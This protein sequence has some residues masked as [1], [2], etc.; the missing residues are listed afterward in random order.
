M[1]LAALLLLGPWNEPIDAPPVRTGSLSLK[2]GPADALLRQ[3]KKLRWEERWFEAAG[4][5]RRY[6]AQFPGS[7]REVDARFWLAVTLEQDQRWD[8]ASDAYGDFLA[9]HP[10]QRQL[11][12]EARMNRI[13]CWGV[14]QGQRPG[15][16]EGLLAALRE[17]EPEIRVAAGL[18]LARVMDRRA[19]PA[20]QEGLTLPKQ[21]D[22]ATLALI[23]L[24]VKPQAPTGL[25]SGRFLV[26]RIQEA[27]KKDTVTIRFAMALARAITGYLSNAQLAEARKK[28]VDVENLTTQALQVPKG[29]ELLSVDDGKSRITVTVE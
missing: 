17:P 15:A 20:L 8:E 6:L 27:G 18:Q 10:D 14:R 4:L 26:I 24:G 3:A 12:R 19:I 22:A 7:S 2:E 1:I 13:R 5:Y 21:A 16:S 9:R 25:A 28:G 29:T 23:S 11:G